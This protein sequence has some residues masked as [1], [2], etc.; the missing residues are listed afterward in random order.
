MPPQF[1]PQFVPNDNV[2]IPE[3][4]PTQQK[5]PHKHAFIITLTFLLV[6]TGVFGVWYFS[7]PLP[8]EES[9]GSTLLTT[10]KF[11]DWKTYKNEK[12]G[13]EI[14][15]PV[16]HTLYSSVNTQNE[17]L[18]PADS[19]SNKVAI[20]ENEKALF[21]CEPTTFSLLVVDEKIT[22]REWIDKNYTKYTSQK[23][24]KSIKDIKFAGTNAVELVG[25][26]NLGSTYKLLVMSRNG[27]L[28]IINQNNKSEFLDEII[29]TFKFS[30]PTANWKTYINEKYG[31]E[32]K[33]PQDKVF[34]LNPLTPDDNFHE[35]TLPLSL[36]LP[37]DSKRN[38]SIGLASTLTV[39]V[40]PKSKYKN[41]VDS[42]RSSNSKCPYENKTP[43]PYSYK[44]I[45]IVVEENIEAIKI[46]PFN[47]YYG[48]EDNIVLFSSSNY[49]YEFSWTPPNKNVEDLFSKIIS[50]FKFNDPTV[51]W[52]TYKSAY[53]NF[54][55]KYPPNMVAREV[56]TKDLIVCFEDENHNFSNG[57][58]VC[59]YD[60]GGLPFVPAPGR[61][62]IEN[63][64]ASQEEKSTVGDYVIISKDFEL[65]DSMISTFKVIQ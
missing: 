10:S 47:Q 65:F 13:F 2:P 57:L 30:D 35:F 59:V 4:N 64:Y 32:F 31:F 40:G 7:N 3:N 9:N 6:L 21:C 5:H 50:T 8:E 11:A 12:Y 63:P 46:N 33:Y 28:L 17:S 48:G 56:F 54:E 19:Q 15:Y 52:K 37:D 45:K 29:S 20:T 51:N 34:L 18:I 60:G 27:Y 61:A 38:S 36:L 39:G 43:C 26:G 1:Q 41:R 22:P 55:V 14:K 62:K 25:G 53:R 49:F 44:E 24:I 42:I 16:D 23:E 58:N